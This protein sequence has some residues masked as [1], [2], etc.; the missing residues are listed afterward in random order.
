VTENHGVGGSI[1]PLGTILLRFLKRIGVEV[2]H[3]VP[4]GRHDA[5]RYAALNLGLHRRIFEMSSNAKLIEIYTRLIKE[6]TLFRRYSVAP[7]VTLHQHSLI[8][9]RIAARDSDGRQR[10]CWR[11]SRA[12]GIES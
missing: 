12:R 6:L 3:L 11:T 8:V 5:A 2:G 7:G 1:P 10:H 9:D 4:V